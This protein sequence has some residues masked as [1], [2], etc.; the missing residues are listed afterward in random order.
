M[1]WVIDAREFNL[2]FTEKEGY[3]SFRWKWARK[4]WRESTK[5]IYF[6]TGDKHR[7]FKVGKIHW[8]SVMKIGDGRVVTPKKKAIYGWGNWV[9][10]KTFLYEN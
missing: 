3:H 9:D 4:S 8:F 10:M 5:D 6:D 2:D 1:I 7:L